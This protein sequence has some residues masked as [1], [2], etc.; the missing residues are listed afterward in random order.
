MYRAPL[1]LILLLILAIVGLGVYGYFTTPLPLGLSSVIQ[2][3]GGANLVPPSAGASGGSTGRRT[4]AGQPLVLGATSVVIQSVQRG[5]DLTTGGRGGPVGTFTVVEI[6][7]QN[8]GNEPLTPQ[9]ANFR[10]V[11]ERGRVYAVDPEATRVLDASNHRRVIFDTTVPPA[12]RVN[13]LLAF[14]TAPDANGLTLRVSLGYGEL[15]LPR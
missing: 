11:D 12:G 1:W 15:E 9:M 3:P 5:Q 4:A 10:L 14:E 7:L 8:G 13:T 2:T 6:E